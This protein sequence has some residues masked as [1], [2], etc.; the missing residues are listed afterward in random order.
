V[1]NNTYVYN[2]RF[3]EDSKRISVP[4]SNKQL[5]FEYTSF[6]SKLYPGQDE[7]WRIKISGEK[8]DKV[9]GEVL[10][11]MYDA[12][13][14]KIYKSGWQ[15][16]IYYPFASGDYTNFY[17]FSRGYTHYYTSYD[18]RRVILSNY[19]KVFR[20]LNWFGFYVGSRYGGGVMYERSAPLRAKK[21]SGIVYATQD[22]SPREDDGE[23]N[24]VKKAEYKVNNNAIS[25]NL[26]N[27]NKNEPEE[28]VQLRTNLNETVF[29]YPNI[30]TDKDGNFVL[31]FKMN[32]ALTKW[33]LRMFAHTKDL[34][35]AYDE[36]EIVTQKEL[37]ITPNNPRFVR[38]GD[39]L[40]F[41]ARIDNLTENKL[42][43]EAWVELYDAETMKPLEK[44]FL[45]GQKN[46]KFDIDE[47]GSALV[48]WDMQ[49][50]KNV[51]NL[52]IYR[53][54]AKA[55]DYSDA[56][57]GF[58]PVL[59]N[60]KLVTETMPLWVKGNET[61]E[62]V[63]KSLKNSK[64]K[65]LKNISF[66][67]EATSH[68]VWLAIQSLPYLKDVSCENSISYTN[69]LFSNLLAKKI[70]EDNPKIKRVFDK[71]KNA[72]TGADKDA[73]L[74]NLSKN[75]ELKNI[76][77][78]ETPWVLDAIDEEQQKRNIALL[79]DLNQVR[80]D[81]YAF[82]RK[83][84]AI[85]NP[86]GG[87]P[88]FQS[89]RSNRYITQYIV[90]TFGRMKKLGL[91]NNER[92]INNILKPAINY[93]NNDVVKQ[94]KHLLELA[95]QGKVDLEKNHLGSLMIHYM[96]AIQF[97]PE[98][99]KNKDLQEA[100]DYYFGQAKKYWLD[101]P[102]YL[103]GMLSLILHRG[104]ETGIAKEILRAAEEQSIISDELGMYWKSYHGYHWWQ[105]PI[106][107]QSLMIEAFYEVNHD[108]NIVDQLKIWLLKNKQTNRWETGK[109]T[110]SAIYALLFDNGGTIGET[111]L[112]K[113]YVAGKDVTTGLSKD[114]I[115]TG[116]GYYKEKWNGNE[117]DPGMA[118]IKIE[119]PNKDIAWGAA[120]WQYLQDLDKIENFEDTPLKIKR[121]L[122]LV[123]NTDKGEKMTEIKEGD[124]LHPGDLIKVKIRLQVDREMEF[125]HLSDQRAA[126]FE[127]LQQLSGYHWQGGLG[128]YQNPRDTKM[129]FFIDFLPRGV[130]VLEYPLRVTQSGTFSNGIA[131]LQS[132]Y[133]PEFSS[134]SEGIR[135]EVR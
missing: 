43:G 59:T 7:E 28:S 88:W 87:F 129:N 19:Q 35:Y 39:K 97:Y 91:L 102:L 75:Q 72:K 86:D 34:K 22:I 25:D 124:V 119:N 116:T 117:V 32:D 134:H 70:T 1:V 58:L 110:V 81:K 13:L 69:A 20:K 107:T 67:I 68:P 41:N 18:H 121:T 111:N 105:L 44:S 120:Y 89:G 42:N 38:E 128:Y 135:V 17:G 36:K 10:A 4:W 84:K 12:S 16:A 127:P 80:N 104:E 14:D 30:V 108:K 24:A 114:D 132:Y 62:F 118:T 55:G 106:E 92:E 99:N 23:M 56:E 49:F 15:K 2:N 90:E 50:P 93:V 31:K 66:T 65:D 47:K 54:Y 8:A 126:T 131:E 40:T 60:Q 46:I 73:L 61:R 63:F 33:K 11:G 76:L 101:R 100:Y 95:A 3:Y 98:I 112:V 48:S 78:E 52:L 123:H 103:K 82:V 71:W 51:S 53:F 130:F 77:L 125:V 9:V 85:Q 5:K 79:F 37:M 74:S 109:A 122:Y 21:E 113:I 96:Y 83:L 27:M 115:Q 45:K 26:D 64:G 6:R 29:F 57:E 94:Y 133:A